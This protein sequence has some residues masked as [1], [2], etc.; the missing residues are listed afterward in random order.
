MKMFISE[1][2]ET[3]SD[4]RSAITNYR[5]VRQVG[6]GSQ[7]QETEESRGALPYWVILG[8]CSQNG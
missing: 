8:M 6:A 3:D 5:C 1:L 7:T 4:R 2:P